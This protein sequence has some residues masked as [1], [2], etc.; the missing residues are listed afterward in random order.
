MFHQIPLKSN[1]LKHII[2]E[3]KLPLSLS[4]HSKC[5]VF[6]RLYN[7][8]NGHKKR[9]RFTQRASSNVAQLQYLP[10]FR[11]LSVSLHVDSM[12]PLPVL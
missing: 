2:V 1:I 9:K 11:T 3:S 6:K 5:Y 8:N 12:M 4:L 7:P 10:S